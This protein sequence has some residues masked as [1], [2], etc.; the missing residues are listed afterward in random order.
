MQAE[1]LLKNKKFRTSLEQA[2]KHDTETLIKY[3]NDMLVLHRHQIDET[4]IDPPN[5]LSHLH[6]EDIPLIPTVFTIGFARRFS[7]Y[8]RADLIFDDIKKLTNIITRLDYPVNFLFAGKAHPNDEPGQQL[9][10]LVHDYSVRPEFIGK[11]I[12]LVF[13][14]IVFVIAPFVTWKTLAS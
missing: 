14:S 7:T 12:L 10:K 5:F 13:G 6:E 11:I 3:V 9:I 4:W 2:W 1:S 8:K